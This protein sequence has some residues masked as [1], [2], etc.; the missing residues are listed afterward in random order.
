MATIKN[1]KPRADYNQIAEVYDYNDKS[2]GQ[3]QRSVSTL[4]QSHDI[5]NV[6]D[7][8]IAAAGKPFDVRPI[9]RK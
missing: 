4:R 7:W 2:I 9:D 3:I 5:T 1:P 6:P 8:A